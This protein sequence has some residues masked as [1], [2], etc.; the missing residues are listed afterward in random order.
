MILCIGHEDLTPVRIQPRMGRHFPFP[1]DH[2]GTLRESGHLRLKTGCIDHTFHQHRIGIEIHHPLQF[3]T[4]MCGGE[5]A[6][7]DQLAAIQGQTDHLAVG[8]THDD[9]T[10]AHDR[11]TA[12]AQG[13]YRHRLGIVP[14]ILAGAGV[15]TADAVVDGT[16][17]H[18]ARFT[19]RGRQHLTPDPAP[20][21]LFTG[22]RIQGDQ[23]GLGGPHQHQL[24]HQPRT[25]A[26]RHIQI[27]LPETLAVFPVDCLHPAF[28]IRQEQPVVAAYRANPQILSF[29]ATDRGLPQGLDLER[30]FEVHQ[31][32][33][34]IR[35]ILGA[36]H[37]EGGQ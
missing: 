23:F 5:Y 32:C 33:R 21:A 18:H 31:L 2:A 36:K 4:T 34:G 20:P 35:I 25:A 8:E 16:D 30:G 17:Y 3:G 7:P 15:D 24:T 10:V 28:R 12:A 29:H 27:H 11:G 9:A 37:T 26:D 19:G 22:L 6:L 14:A 13:Q 1:Q